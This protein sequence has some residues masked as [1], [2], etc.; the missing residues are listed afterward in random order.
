[1]LKR[2]K[3]GDVRRAFVAWR[4]HS[5]LTILSEMADKFAK[6]TVKIVRLSE[7]HKRNTH[8]WS[9]ELLRRH[10][11]VWGA[12]RR[13]ALGDKARRRCILAF[14]MS[15]NERGTMQLAF[16]TWLIDHHANSHLEVK[17]QRILDDLNGKDDEVTSL[18]IK[19]RELEAE[20]SNVRDE[21]AKVDRQRSVVVEQRNGLQV[22][23]QSAL[24][25]VFRHMCV[26]TAKKSVS[27]CFRL[28]HSY[29]TGHVKDA[30]MNSVVERY[31]LEQQILANQVVSSRHSNGLMLVSKC[32]RQSEKDRVR[33]SFQR[34]S[35]ITT[36]L[37]RDEHEGRRKMVDGLTLVWRHCSRSHTNQSARVLSASFYRWLRIGHEMANVEGVEAALRR[38]KNDTAVKFVK[39]WARKLQSAGLSTWCV[40]VRCMKRRDELCRKILREMA[41][42]NLNAGFSTW[43]SRIR[44][45][46]N[47]AN[48]H[49]L[50]SEAER[51]RQ[52]RLV[53]MMVNTL[54]GG[55]H[56]AMHHALTLWS[57]STDHHRSNEEDNRNKQI[58]VLHLMEEKGAKAELR[59]RMHAFHTW[60]HW[61]TE[62]KHS[63]SYN[64]LSQVTQNEYNAMLSQLEDARKIQHEQNNAKQRKVL[65][66][67]ANMYTELAFHAWCDMVTKY[68]HDQNLVAKFIGRFEHAALN[69]SMMT[70]KHA[71][72]Y[73]KEMED[74]QRM[75]EE[76]LVKQSEAEISRN[77]L[78]GAVQTRNGK[79]LK[80]R[81]FMKWYR[82]FVYSLTRQC[83]MLETKVEKMERKDTITTNWARWSKELAS[84]KH[85]QRTISRAMLHILHLKLS[86]GVTAWL[87]YVHLHRVAERTL[88]TMLRVKIHIAFV[89]WRGYVKCFNGISSLVVG[90]ERLGY[91]IALER[92]MAQ[93]STRTVT[94]KRIGILVRKWMRSVTHDAFRRMFKASTDSMIQRLID[95]HRQS[96]IKSVLRI[97]GS[98]KSKLAPAFRTW[99]QRAATLTRMRKSLALVTKR[100]SNNGTRTCL[101]V[102]METWRRS[103]DRTDRIVGLVERVFMR[104]IT[105]DT[106]MAFRVWLE[107]ARL[108]TMVRN[109]MVVMMSNSKKNNV[110]SAFRTWQR[111]ARLAYRASY[112]AMWV[113]KSLVQKASNH[114]KSAMKHWRSSVSMS[115]RDELGCK[116]SDEMEHVKNLTL[117]I[118]NL[119]SEKQAVADQLSYCMHVLEYVMANQ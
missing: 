52:V 105:M 44:A 111:H 55:A 30:Y 8:A 76:E 75:S 7:W 86:L 102:A 82:C 98:N 58:R 118:T 22:E 113:R 63:D 41:A 23:K 117:T 64:K 108:K 110:S 60:Q 29:T 54:Q 5:Q 61:C 83:R 116:L 103:L 81:A 74:A 17:S 94:K 91:T 57:R 6:S 95:D 25:M 26:V 106:A 45:M 16:R 39:K 48:L 42:T 84:A 67:L 4:A 9:R 85:G 88:R 101:R 89:T 53:S 68:H 47:E 31:E 50:R 77:M 96:K 70:W 114:L 78:M 100:V 90:T 20:L 72:R 40:V 14:V 51:A 18:K 73:M 32:M 38:S 24:E 99:R 3:A 69:G 71:I 35:A 36:D 21:L 11:T 13:K 65:N 10:W 2:W 79:R 115:I 62:Q 43:R 1:M 28:W 87:G 49:A 109:R 27:V 104:W 59:S 12:F 97:V 15:R 33:Y 37:L 93:W 107:Y 112:A 66:K 119:E 34:W 19:V 56:F 80:S 46:V 92:A